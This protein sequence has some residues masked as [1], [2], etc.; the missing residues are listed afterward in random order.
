M[1][2]L[3]KIQF[4][5]M[6]CTKEKEKCYSLLKVQIAN[7]LTSFI[8]AKKD[9]SSSIIICMVAWLSINLYSF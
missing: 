8:F 7:S 2:R 5:T 6:T 3:D 9:S 1:R 4:Q